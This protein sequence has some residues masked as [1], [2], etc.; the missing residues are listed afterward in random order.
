MRIL[1]NVKL[2][3]ALD[4]RHQTFSLGTYFSTLF[5]GDYLGELTLAEFE[6]FMSLPQTMETDF[7]RDNRRDRNT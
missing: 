6:I 5:G 3:E 2:H 4:T 7:L 1:Q